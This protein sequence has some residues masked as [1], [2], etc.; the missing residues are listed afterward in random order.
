MCW[1]TN[2]CRKVLL[3]IYI[4][5]EN[6]CLV[7]LKTNKK[8]LFSFCK[9]CHLSKESLHDLTG[10]LTLPWYRQTILIKWNSLILNLTLHIFLFDMVYTRTF[11]KVQALPIQLHHDFFI[12]IFYFFWPIPSFLVKIIILLRFVMIYKT[13]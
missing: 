11:K 10:K 8:F 12:F 2:T 9:L 5:Q 6:T 13:C 4:I 3:A 1:S 7:A